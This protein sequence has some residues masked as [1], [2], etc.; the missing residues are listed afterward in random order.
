[1]NVKEKEGERESERV[2]EMRFGYKP[3]SRAQFHSQAI[4][5]VSGDYLTQ[6]LYQ[7]SCMRFSLV[8]GLSLEIHRL[9]D[10]LPAWHPRLLN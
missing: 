5:C 8:L 9:Q 3:H 6:R 10:L 2:R 7:D 4:V 1:M